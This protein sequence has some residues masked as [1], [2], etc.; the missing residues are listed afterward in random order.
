MAYDNLLVHR[1]RSGS[2]VPVIRKGNPL[3]GLPRP[4]MRL[5]DTFV[6]HEPTIKSGVA[7]SKD[8]TTI[9]DVRKGEL[10]EYQRT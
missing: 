6:V 9:T 2:G 8:R 5:K 7:Q 10:G 1:F 4:S 3:V